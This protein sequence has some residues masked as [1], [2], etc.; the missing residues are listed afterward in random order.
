MLLESKS[1]AEEGSE[2]VTDIATIFESESQVFG[3]NKV[4][5]AQ[6]NILPEKR[7][8]EG[9][10]AESKVLGIPVTYSDES[11]S[12]FRVQKKYE[13]AKALTLPEQASQYYSESMSLSTNLNFQFVEETF[14]A[15]YYDSNDCLAALGGI[16]V[17]VKILLII[18]AWL[19]MVHYI[20]ALAEMIQRKAL[21]NVEVNK[22]KR[23]M[24]KLPE[25]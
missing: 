19:V 22:M 16:L 18:L 23:C 14:I 21:N 13:V 4:I 10:V 12:M 2:V 7:I 3:D 1:K 6:V 8:Y 25:I 5:R 9:K 11:E 15:S 20:Y 17:Y 24:N